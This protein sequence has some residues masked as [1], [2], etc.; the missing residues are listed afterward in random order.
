MRAISHVLIKRKNVSFVMRE[1]YLF[2]MMV[3]EV[4]VQQNRAK[5]GGA[6]YA[7][8]KSLKKVYNCSGLWILYHQSVRYVQLV[9]VIMLKVEVEVEVM[10]VVVVVAGATLVIVAA[11]VVMVAVI[12]Q[13]VLGNSY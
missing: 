9:S 3:R 12:A 7:E 8:T 13:V 5:D 2:V 6:I 11:V 1:L 4:I 10:L